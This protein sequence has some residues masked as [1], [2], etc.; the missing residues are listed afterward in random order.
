MGIIPVMRLPFQFEDAAYATAVGEISPVIET[1][2]GFHIVKV[3]AKT[4]ARGQVLVEHILKL[5][6]GLSDAEAAA[7]KAQIDSPR[8]R[9][10]RLAPRGWQTPLVRSRTDGA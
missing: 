1:P 4:P 2:F 7:K 6:Q 10:S 9:R 3:N 8:K 5:T